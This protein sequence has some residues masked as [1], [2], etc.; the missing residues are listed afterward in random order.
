MAV[1]P[2]R[3]APVPARRSV[4]WWPVLLVAAVL[5]AAGFVAGKAAVGAVIAARWMWS[6]IQLGWVES[7]SDG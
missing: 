2:A 7:R 5:Y 1:I 6:A 3:R 4:A